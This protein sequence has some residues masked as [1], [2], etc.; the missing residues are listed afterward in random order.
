MPLTV[1]QSTTFFTA[2][3][4]M[5]L[6][7]VQRTALAAQGLSTPDDFSD[8]VTDELDTGLKNMRTSIPAVA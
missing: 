7:P 4:Q 6:T 3:T 2:G 1:G 5:G 8:F